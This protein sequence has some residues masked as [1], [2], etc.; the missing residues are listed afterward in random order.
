MLPYGVAGQTATQFLE[1]LTIHFREHHRGMYLT[2]AQFRQLFQGF[3]AVIV[4]GGID[5]EGNQ[6]LIGMQPGILGPEIFCF[7]FLNGLN[8]TLWNELGLVVNACQIFGGIEQQSGRTTQ[9]G[10]D[11]EVIM[12]PSSSSIAAAVWPL[13]SFLS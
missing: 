9:Q 7:G 5:T 13:S 12:V 8:Q 3:A 1:D 11:F 10:E 6:Y 2:V 4:V